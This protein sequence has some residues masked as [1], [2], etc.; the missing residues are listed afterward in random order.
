MRQNS[1]FSIAP[2][3]ARCTFEDAPSVPAERALTAMP[4]QADFHKGIEPAARPLSAASDPVV[5]IAV[6]CI[7]A[8][9]LINLRH[10]RRL[11]GAF[12]S[13]ITGSRQRSNV[14]ETTGYENRAVVLLSLLF[15]TVGAI[16]LYIA[17]A[18]A[19]ISVLLTTARLNLLMFSFGAMSMTWYLIHVLGY[20]LIGWTFGTPEHTTAWLRSFNL[21]M[22]VFSLAALFPVVTALYIPQTGQNMAIITIILFI[23]AISVP[24]IKGFRIFYSNFFS[25]LYFILYLCAI[26]IVPLITVYV[27]ARSVFRLL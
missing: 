4:P 27:A 16:I 6:F 12:V 21:S 10:T 3:S 15:C 14:A 18:P 24:I 19:G 13:D 26:E 17:A 5:T 7:L 25:V 23:L 20:R 11:F 8:A 1:Y 22:G 9:V 2:D